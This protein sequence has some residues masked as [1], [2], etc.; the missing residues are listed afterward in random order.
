MPFDRDYQMN[1]TG[2]VDCGAMDR[3]NRGIQAHSAPLGV[4]FF[5]NTNAPD[6]YRAGAAAGLHGSWN[7]SQKTGYKVAY[8]PWD[9]VTQLPGD[10][11]DLVSG[12]ADAFSNWG[13]P[14]DVAVDPSGAILISDDQTGTIYKLTYSTTLPPPDQS[15]TGFTLIDAGSGAP[16]GGYDPIPAGATL[17]LATLPTQ[18]VNIRANT[19]PATVG[20]VRFALDGN[21]SYSTDNASPYVLPWTPLVGSHSVTATPFAGADASGIAG[22]AQTLSFKVIDRRKGKP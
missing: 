10:Q 2:A 3:I 12:W 16:V 20:S 19:S 17:N 9:E 18:N 1:Q 15:V 13:R 22:T 7:R 4:T 8:F 11:I 21:A 5:Q 14:V 6:L